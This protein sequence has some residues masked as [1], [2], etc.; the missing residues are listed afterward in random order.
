MKNKYIII[1]LTTLI[2][3]G[4]LPDAKGDPSADSVYCYY[5][6]DSI[7]T[8]SID[9]STR[10]TVNVLL[11]YVGFT[12][13]EPTYPSLTLPTYW[14]VIEDTLEYY[15]MLMT[16]GNVT[17]N[18]TTVQRPGNASDS[19]YVAS[20][21]WSYWNNYIGNNYLYSALGE[22]NDEIIEKVHSDYS[23]IF[24]NVD[25]VFMAFHHGPIFAAR[26]FGAIA[27]LGYLHN[28]YYQG[29]GTS[30]P[31]GGGGY[32]PFISTLVHEYGHVLEL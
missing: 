13:R 22:L 16:D 23:N 8:M 9:P 24:D 1:L 3:G 6:P 2:W 25:A 20:H 28:P 14:Q 26:G 18:V 5:D 30:N 4:M 32:H 19:C 15:Y 11:I 21:T 12:D 31:F 17:F 10:S 27:T 29:P 7:Q